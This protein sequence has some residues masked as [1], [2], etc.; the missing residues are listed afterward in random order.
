MATRVVDD[1]SK[2]SLRAAEPARQG[3][4]GPRHCAVVRW[5][6]G[7]ARIFKPPLLLAATVKLPPIG[8]Q[9]TEHLA[10]LDR[11]FRREDVSDALSSFA[12]DP[13]CPMATVHFESVDVAFNASQIRSPFSTTQPGRA[14]SRHRHFRTIGSR[15]RVTGP[16]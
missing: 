5:R 15:G 3:T 14:L 8:K 12:N 13:Q 9:T 6:A 16:A 7:S 2:C 4:I 11:R 1:G 10:F